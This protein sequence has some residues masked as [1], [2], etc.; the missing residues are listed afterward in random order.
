MVRHIVLTSVFVFQLGL[1]ISDLRLFPQ[2]L[3]AVTLD[4]RLV[5]THV[6]E[7]NEP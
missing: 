1:Q 2:H 6:P 4:P 7:N 5:I 3:P